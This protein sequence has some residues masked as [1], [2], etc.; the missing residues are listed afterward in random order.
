MKIQ[1]CPRIP[2]FLNGMA[3]RELTCKEVGVYDKVVASDVYG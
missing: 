1:V 2:A 3:L